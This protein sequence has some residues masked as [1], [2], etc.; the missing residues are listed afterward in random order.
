MRRRI[1][2]LMRAA[3]LSPQKQSRAWAV[4]D[5]DKEY[6]IMRLSQPP[7]FPPWVFGKVHTTHQAPMGVWPEKVHASEPGRNCNKMETNDLL[8]SSSHIE[9]PSF[10]CLFL[11][12][13]NS[14]NLGNCIALVRLW[15][16][17]LLSTLAAAERR[18][19]FKIAWKWNFESCWHTKLGDVCSTAHTGPRTRQKSKSI[20]CDRVNPKSRLL[21]LDWHAAASL[22]WQKKLGLS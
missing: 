6:Y 4:R 16:L 7:Y 20:S 14:R 19:G 10:C 5:E 15:K 12:W 11:Y 1:S 8:S 9:S 22:R 3:R 18:R 2:C 21:N 17:F 13:R